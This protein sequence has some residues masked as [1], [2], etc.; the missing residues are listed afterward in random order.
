MGQLR[1]ALRA[2]AATGLGPGPL[3]DALDQY[4]RRHSV[5]QM[6]TVV[7]AELDLVSG[8]LRYACAG[9]PP[10]VVARPGAGA[11]VLWEGRSMPLNVQAVSEKDRAEGTAEL[12]RGS[13]LL[14]Y[15]DG[16]VERRGIPITDG[17]GVLADALDAQ[18]GESSDVLVEGLVES[19]LEGERG[20]DVCVLAAR[21]MSG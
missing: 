12:E 7:Y 1:S 10:P 6:T 4:G 8:V 2:L 18:H 3:L 14:L 21:L 11:Q 17:I 16:L 20:D 5:G 15:T 9:H 19:L 13:T